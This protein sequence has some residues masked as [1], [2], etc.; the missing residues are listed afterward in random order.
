[1]KFYVVKNNLRDYW[2]S[3]S[4]NYKLNLE[5]NKSAWD[6]EWVITI[7][8]EFFVFESS[9]SLNIIDVWKSRA[10]EG[11]SKIKIGFILEITF[12]REHLWACPPEIFLP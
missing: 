2:E 12:K 8:I 4:Q 7:K 9:N 6:L 1:M 3:I 5:E 10:E 11:S